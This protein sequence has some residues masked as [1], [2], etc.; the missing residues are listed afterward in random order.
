MK[1]YKFRGKRKDNKEWVYGCY[2][3]RWTGTT[4]KHFIH[5][6]LLEYE[7]DPS[8]IG[9]YTGLHDKNGREIYEGDIVKLTYF[10][11]KEDSII[12]PVQ[13][14]YDWDCYGIRFGNYTIEQLYMHYSIEV[15]DNVHDNPELWEGI[16]CWARS[17]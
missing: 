12:K 8:T 3:K 9:Q 11:N 17:N 10:E 4:Y 7:V 14:H 15:I 5:D 13:W 2:L 16:A 6:G 1:E